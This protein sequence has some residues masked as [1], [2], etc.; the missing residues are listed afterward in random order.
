[1]PGDENKC[2]NIVVEKP[3]REQEKEGGEGGGE[4]RKEIQ[5]PH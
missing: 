1:V 3:G 4:G 5:R 2:G